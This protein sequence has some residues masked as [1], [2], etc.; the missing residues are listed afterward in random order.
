MKF[1]RQSKSAAN[2]QQLIGIDADCV[3]FLKACLE[4]Q[5]EIVLKTPSHKGLVKFLQAKLNLRITRAD[6][7]TN[8]SDVRDSND[9]LKSLSTSGSLKSTQSTTMPRVDI[10]TTNKKLRKLIPFYHGLKNHGNTCFMNS[11]VQSIVHIEPFCLY[12]LSKNI[13]N[14]IYLLQQQQQTTENNRPQTVKNFYLFK[15][16]NAL[17]ISL[18]TNKYEQQYSLEFKN[19]CG[20]LNQQ[21]SGQDQNDALEFCLW[22]LNN[23]ND[24]LV[25]FNKVRLSEDKSFF[26]S[27]VTGG[28]C[29]RHNKCLVSLKSL[30]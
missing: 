11:I 17:L 13:M 16:F 25:Q 4:R 1:Q 14:Q 18:W 12:F 28:A 2:Q 23:L 15:T 29:V 22:F 6:K 3:N 26:A 19:L 10:Q 8:H 30:N 5:D 20:F 7:T 24:E 21:F 27:K 9:D